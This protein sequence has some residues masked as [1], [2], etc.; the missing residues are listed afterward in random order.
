MRAYTTNDQ[1]GIQTPG[2]MITPT[3]GTNVSPKTTSITDD[4]E[5]GDEDDYFRERMQ[6]PSEVM[7]VDFNK[8][9]KELKRAMKEFRDDLENKD[10]M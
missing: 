7:V 8:S 4:R 2:T 6:R 10:S 9:T 1:E 3:Q 5:S